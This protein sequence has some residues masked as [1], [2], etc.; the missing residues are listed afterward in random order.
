MAPKA[1][2]PWSERPRLWGGVVADVGSKKTAGFNT[3]LTPI[4]RVQAE[5]HTS[6]RAEPKSHQGKVRS[7]KAIDKQWEKDCATAL[8]KGEDPPDRPDAADAGV[9]PTVRQLLSN[10]TTQERLAELM[11]QNPRGIVLYRDELSGWF[12]SFNQYRPGADEQFY[13]QCHAGG[14]WQQDRKIARSQDRKIARSQDRKIGNIWIEDLYLNIFGGFQHE[15][16]AEVLTRR[17]KPGAN[18]SADNGLTARFSLLV[19]PD[20][21]NRLEW[22]DRKLDADTRATVENLFRRLLA[23]DTERF[24]GPRSGNATHYPPLRF[25]PEGQDGFANGTWTTTKRG[26]FRADRA[27]QR[28][29]L[30]I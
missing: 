5:F 16:V 23:L 15:V 24:V 14:A 2:D 3:V 25:T 9:A 6:H 1:L 20:Q 12:A 17:A 10:D 11:Q 19:W 18:K 4:W 28:P 7:A 26:R 29:L 8:G 27:A 21:I 13:L 22:V 30:Q